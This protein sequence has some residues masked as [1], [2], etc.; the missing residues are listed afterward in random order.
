MGAAAPAGTSMGSPRAGDHVVAGGVDRQSGRRRTPTRAAARR[1]QLGHDAVAQQGKRTATAGSIGQRGTQ[2]DEGQ[3][4]RP[5]Q[6][7]GASAP[8]ATRPWGRRVAGRREDPDPGQV[9]VGQQRV[10]GAHQR[11]RGLLDLPVTP[12][13]ARRWAGRWPRTA[14]G[15]R[16]ARS[17]G[18]RS[19]G[20]RRA[21]ARCRRPVDL[22]PGIAAEQR[23]EQRVVGAG[24]EHVELAPAGATA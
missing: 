8:P 14:P 2:V 12:P 24:D 17:P 18:R 16:P 3:P 4:P 23:V 20:R 21:R 9:D 6:Q 10:V 19:P 5:H 11:R 13:P 22:T 7:R 15:G 1:R